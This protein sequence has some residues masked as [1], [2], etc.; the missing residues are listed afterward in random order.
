MA[1]T[2]LGHFVQVQPSAQPAGVT[3]ATGVTVEPADLLTLD[4]QLFQAV[5]GDAGGTWDPA[6]I[7]SIG[8]AGMWWA[9][10]GELQG[11]SNVLTPLGSGVRVTFGTNDWDYYYAGTGGAGL[12]PATS[13]AI[14][15]SPASM[16]SIVGFVCGGNEAQSTQVGAQGLVPLRCHQDA[17]LDQVIL[18][19]QVASN[20]AGGLPFALAKMRVIAVDPLGNITP[21]RTTAPAD[22]NGYVPLATPAN[23]AAWFDGGAQQ[24]CI[25]TIDANTIVDRTKYSYLVQ[26]VDESGPNAE[27]GNKVLDVV[28][29]FKEIVWGNPQ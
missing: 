26:V 25:Y 20:H 29:S 14:H 6:E 23:G 13:R 19:F 16:V 11:G 21:L 22:A 18:T 17:E 9:G 27:I 10:I 24:E 1:A 3:W 5:N 4:Q 12:H 2:I 15:T 8:G 28:A 7:L